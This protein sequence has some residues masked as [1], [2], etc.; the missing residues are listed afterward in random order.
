VDILCKKWNR[1]TEWVVKWGEEL[2]RARVF[3]FLNQEGRFV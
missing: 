3:N 1:L 2:A